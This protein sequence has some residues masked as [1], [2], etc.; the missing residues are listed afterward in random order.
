VTRWDALLAGSS[1]L[2]MVGEGLKPLHFAG[3]FV[4][5]GARPIR[6]AAHPDQGGLSDEDGRP[7]P[8]GAE[9]TTAEMNWHLLHGH[10]ERRSKA[11]V[12]TCKKRRMHL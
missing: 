4:S 11:G 10:R 8:T 3:C 7:A 5:G 9:T 12:M 6:A 1:S 2:G